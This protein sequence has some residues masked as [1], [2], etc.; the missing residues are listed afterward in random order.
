MLIN[1]YLADPCGSLSIPYWKNKKMN[2]PPDIKI[3][4][5]K[6]FKDKYLVNYTDEKYFRLIHYLND[7]KQKPVPGFSI[8]TADISDIH[9]I[10]EV[11]NKSYNDLSVNYHQILGLTKLPVHNSNLWV[12]LIENSSENIVGCGIADFDEE[13]KE[14][15]LEWIQILPDYRGKKLG[16]MIVNEL[17]CRMKR[18]EFATVSGKINNPTNPERL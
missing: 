15:I 3:V 4:H 18:A 8:R 13:V 16:K 7:V 11:I 1:D 10:V 12:L 2:V 17:L 14:G 5:H 6:N 9:S